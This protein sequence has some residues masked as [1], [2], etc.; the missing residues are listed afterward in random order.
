VNFSENYAH[1]TNNELLMAAASR[2]DLIQEAAIAMDSEMVQR[3]L[4]YEDA[5]AKKKRVARLQIRE[6]RKRRRSPKGTR[7]LVAEVR[8]RWMLL[9]LS[10]TLL[11]ILLSFPKIVSEQWLLPIIFAA[12]GLVSAISG[13]QPRLRR[14]R[15]FWLSL[16]L[17]FIVQLLIGH[18]IIVRLIPHSRSQLKGAA[19]L[20]IFAGY[21]VGVPLFLLLEKANPKANPHFGSI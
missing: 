13:V 4:S 6:A 2:A 1:L 11:I 9:L 14:T 21:A 15:S 7:Y 19:F 12:F 17:G 8:G 20:A 18:L 5:H 3:G 10:P 16:P